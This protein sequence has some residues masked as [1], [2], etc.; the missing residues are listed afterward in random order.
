VRI[1]VSE[2]V[3]T[4]LARGFLLDRARVQS[5]KKASCST[6]VISAGLTSNKRRR[7]GSRVGCKPRQSLSHTDSDMAGAHESED[8]DEDSHCDN[9]DGYGQRQNNSGPFQIKVEAAICNYKY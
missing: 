2:K 5:S 8:D 3:D 4:Q 7:L 1:T 6:L 9:L